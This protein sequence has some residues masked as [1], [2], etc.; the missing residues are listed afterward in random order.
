MRI[1]SLLFLVFLSKNAISQEKITLLHYNIKELDS[2]KIKGHKKNR[3]IQAV[4]KILSRYKPDILSINEIQYD[5]PFI[6]DSNFTTRGQ[7][8]K[9][10]SSILNLY[11]NTS[12]NPANTGLKAKSKKNGAYF[13]NPNNPKARLLADKINFG[14]MPAQYSTGLISRYPIIEEKVFTSIK[15]KDFNPNIELKKFKTSDGSSYPKNIELFDKNFSDITLKVGSK[16]IHIIVLH[17]VPSYHFGNKHS[18]N[19]QRNRDQLRFLEWYLTGETDIHVKLK[20]I[21]PENL[22]QASRI[23]GVNPS[24]VSILSMFLKRKK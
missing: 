11:K 2:S 24:D 8:L 6:P 23:S 13:L 12:F 16:N 7:N 20:R 10:L 14:T 4:K 9:K 22:G 17:T 19:Y 5:L 18:P 3:Q 1:Y 21:K 15:W